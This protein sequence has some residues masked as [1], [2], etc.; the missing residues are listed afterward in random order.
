MDVVLT[1]SFDA[2]IP[3]IGALQFDVEAIV[4]ASGPLSLQCGRGSVQWAA[5]LTDE[6]I[7][8]LLLA[9]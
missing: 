1:D 7:I 8:A 2:I 4:P 3:Q 5:S 6:E 9:V